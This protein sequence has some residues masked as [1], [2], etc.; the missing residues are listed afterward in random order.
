MHPAT[1]ITPA[2]KTDAHQ[3]KTARAIPAKNWFLFVK[4]ERNAAS[5]RRTARQLLTEWKRKLRKRLPE[6]WRRYDCRSWESSCFLRATA[7]RRRL[8][9]FQRHDIP[10]QA[11]QEVMMRRCAPDTRIRSWY[12]HRAV[13]GA[14]FIRPMTSPSLLLH[15]ANDDRPVSA[16]E[17]PSAVR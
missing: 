4:T 14:T 6:Q 2:N 12:D 5:F 8:F 17:S 11:A 13:S 15:V 16:E 9:S 1:A 7:R 10:Q 3:I